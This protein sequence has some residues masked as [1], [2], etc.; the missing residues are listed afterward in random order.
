MLAAWRMSGR[1]SAA[2]DRELAADDEVGLAG[3]EDVDRALVEVGVAEVDLVAEDEVAA[4]EQDALLQ[5]LAVVRLAQADDLHLPVA[6]VGV[7]GGELVAD[8]DGAVLRAVLGQDDLVAP[9]ERLQSLAEVDDGG[10]EDRLLVVDGD[11]DR[12]VRV[13]PAARRRSRVPSNGYYGMR[14]DRVRQI[15]CVARRIR[16][17]EARDERAR[18][19][20][21]V[22]DRAVGPAAVATDATRRRA[23]QDARRGARARRASA[24]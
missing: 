10:V 21:V 22:L 9:A 4:R 2:P 18:L 3:L 17:A 23:V 13:R 1:S 11:D 20:D 16:A 8:L 7:L 24:A 15:Y 19:D 12:D 14:D 5:R 6:R